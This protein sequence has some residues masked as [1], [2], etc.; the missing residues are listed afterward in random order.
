MARIRGKNTSPELKVRRIA[1]GL[2]LRFRLHRRDFPGK[3]DMLMPRHRL[4]VFV[5]GCFWHRHEGCARATI[6]K[7]RTEFWM[8]KLA[9]NVE[10]DA[11]QQGE[12]RALG[13]KVL[14]I[15]QCELRDPSA[16]AARLIVSAGEKSGS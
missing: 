10:R 4:A 16:V 15:W 12:L 6:P 1:H 7:T 3:P 9:C 11:I 2:G 5:H 14:T 13:W 8:K